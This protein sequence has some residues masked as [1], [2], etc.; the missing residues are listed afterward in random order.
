MSSAPSPS[1]PRRPSDA[2]YPAT[3]VRPWRAATVRVR[4]LGRRFRQRGELHRDHP[5]RG[6]LRRS[7]PRRAQHAIHQVDRAGAATSIG[8]ARSS[9]LRLESL[10]N[11]LKRALAGEMS[12]SSDRLLRA[13]ARILEASRLTLE[14]EMVSLD[15]GASAEPAARLRTQMMEA[16][17]A[18]KRA[19]ETFLVLHDLPG[20]EIGLWLEGQRRELRRNASRRSRRR[21]GSTPTFELQI[22]EAHEWGRHRRVGISA[23]G[24][25]VHLLLE[26]G[27]FFK[28]VAVQAVKARSLLRVARSASGP[29]DRRSPPGRKQPTGGVGVQARLRR[30]RASGARVLLRAHRR[31]RR[32]DGGPGD[33]AGRGRHG[34]RAPPVAARPRLDRG[35]ARGA[36]R[37]MTRATYEGMARSASWTSRASWVNADSSAVLAPIVREIA[38]ALGRAGRAWC[39]DATCAPDGATR[40]LH[41]DRRAPREGAH[42]PSAAARRVRP[43]R[44]REAAQPARAGAVTPGVHR[45]R[46]RRS[47]RGGDGRDRQG[48]DD[49]AGVSG[50][51]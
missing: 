10:G 48:R 20:S 3:P 49:R 41:H 18:A 1:S 13:G 44:A 38:R 4:R 14:S 15:I 9:G 16:R 28:K 30:R 2:P 40:D 8:R 36:G 17:A 34:A 47:R 29:R 50:G 26:S 42:P 25:E 19:L 39:C 51:A 24:T 35:S 21:S 37:R 12:T 6:R 11:T 32:R 31:G 7:A 43:L 45:D 46:G 22:L 23:P 27:L 33:R 5:A